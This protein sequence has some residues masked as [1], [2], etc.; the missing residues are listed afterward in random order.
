MYGLG[1]WP[2]RYPDMH[3]FRHSELLSQV[4]GGCL[5]TCWITAEVCYVYRGLLNAVNVFLGCFFRCDATVRLWK[6]VYIMLSYRWSTSIA[7]LPTE[8][9]LLYKYYEGIPNKRV[10][11]LP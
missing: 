4:A 2:G 8:H 9:L 3:G 11:L 10:N 1:S 6:A 7:G 5:T